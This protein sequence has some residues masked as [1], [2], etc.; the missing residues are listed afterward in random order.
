M[1]KMGQGSMWLLGGWF[2]VLMLLWLSDASLGIFENMHKDQLDEM[3]T[4][5]G[6]SPLSFPG[7]SEGLPE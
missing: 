7:R 1:A 6:C 3:V 4:L 2:S 5:K